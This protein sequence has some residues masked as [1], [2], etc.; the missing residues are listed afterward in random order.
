VEIRLN[1]RKH[2]HRRRRIVWFFLIIVLAVLLSGSW[3]YYQHWLESLPSTETVELDF[4]GNPK[5]IFLK[6][7][8]LNTPA[9]GTGEELMLPLDVVQQNIDLNAYYEEKTQSFIITTHNK[10]IRFQTE[11][12][13][14]WVNEES[15]TLKLPVQKIGE[16]I[17]IPIDI[18]QDYY[19][20]EVREDVT[21]GA[22]FLLQDGD[23]LQKGIIKVN[24]DQSELAVHLRTKASIKAPIAAD[25]HDGDSVMI[26][27]EQTGWY[28][29][30]L[31]NGWK[32]FVPEQNLVLGG[33]EVIRYEPENQTT[34]IPWRP[35]GGKINL[36]WEAVYNNIPDTKSF[37]NMPG[38]NVISPTWFAIDD[39]Q[40]N[41]SNK[42]NKSFVTWAH[43]KGYQVWALF[44]NDF[45]ADR[46][47]IVL[48]DYKTRLHIIRQLLSYAELYNLQGINIDFENVYLKDKG[49]L[50]QFVRE[51]T[52]YLHEQNL[53][54]SIDV[55]IRGGSEMWSLFADREALSQTVDYMMVMTY[56]EHWATSP[57]AGSVASLP[58]TEAGIVDIM[59]EDKV[60][61]NK[62]ILGVPYYTRIWSE[63]FIDNKK[64]ITSKAVGMEAIDK[65]LKEKKLTPVFDEA[66]G[67]DYV[68]YTEEGVL[69]RI[70]IENEKSM[71]ARMDIVKK[72][73]LAGIG[74][75]SRVFS[76]AA[77]WDAIKDALE[78][79]P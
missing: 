62:L 51:L 66:V 20:F 29:I 46:T 1:P 45:D 34:N 28:H 13:T 47:S 8:Q 56:D 31:D 30:Q 5:P 70:W 10:V 68:E 69:N 3:V 15:Y 25:L 14:A 44:S 59:R 26:I 48:A 41:L 33:V 6:G 60:P 27:S 57:V 50:T 55:T 19:Q 22:V 42:A 52:P 9:S 18:L 43:G 38:V 35:L 79:K 17:Y 40:G 73:N 32:G 12:L 36:T 71:K 67:Q 63:E 76:N 7:N 39:A 64:K 4:D 78:K 11:Q 49:K 16:I 75:W 53:V 77:I 37:D 65:L 54:V 23:I 2:N 61:A 21:T 72:Y 58:W 74:S 24:K